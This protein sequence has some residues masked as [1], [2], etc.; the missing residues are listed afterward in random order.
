MAEVRVHVYRCDLVSSMNNFNFQVLKWQ[1]STVEWT[2]E[3]RDCRY[4]VGGPPI[5]LLFLL[6]FSLPQVTST[7]SPKIIDIVD[8]SGSGDIDTSA[9]GEMDEERFV[10]GLTGRK[11]KIPATW[12]AQ[13]NKLHLGVLKLFAVASDDFHGEWKKA[14]KDARWLAKHAEATASAMA[15]TLATTDV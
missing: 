3:L 6:I 7:G 8:T 1:F 15:K 12:S 14:R 13:D 9:I 10:K 11:L 5:R 4:S 2:Q